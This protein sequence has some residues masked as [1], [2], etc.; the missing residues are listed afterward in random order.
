MCFAL[1]IQLTRGL[2]RSRGFVNQ[3]LL[4]WI[5]PTNKTYKKGA[6]AISSVEF[7]LIANNYDDAY[8]GFNMKI[9]QL[10]R[11]VGLDRDIPT[12]VRQNSFVFPN[13]V[14]IPI[15]FPC[16][17]HSQSPKAIRLVQG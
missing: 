16:F 1:Q 7:L 13:D 4:Y 10:D 14:S 12:E 8:D 3:T 15:C 17:L 2:L 11:A 9:D 6:F 5:K